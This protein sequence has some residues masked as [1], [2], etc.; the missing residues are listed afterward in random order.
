M[1]T[2]DILEVDKVD[3]TSAIPSFRM[4]V[5]LTIQ[6][7]AFIQRFRIKT[8]DMWYYIKVYNPAEMELYFIKACDS[9]ANQRV[10][11]KLSKETIEKIKQKYLTEHNEAMF[12]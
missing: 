2:I 10:K 6:I 8:Y 1:T 7:N 9:S 5:K 3:Y 4:K 11:Q 12:I